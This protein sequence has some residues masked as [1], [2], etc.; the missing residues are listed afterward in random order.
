[1]VLLS[2]MMVARIFS[3][4]YL[5]TFAMKVLYYCINVLCA[6]KC[7]SRIDDDDE[8]SIYNAMSSS[9]KFL[10]SKGNTFL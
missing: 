6:V 8:K 1:M 2:Q 4:M 9:L 7:F 10:A 3:V 5:S